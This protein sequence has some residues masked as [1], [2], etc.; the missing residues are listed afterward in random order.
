M[1]GRDSESRRWVAR[2]IASERGAGSNDPG[3]L[4]DSGRPPRPPVRP[5]RPCPED[6]PIDL[7]AL[8]EPV[9]GAVVAGLGIAVLGLLLLSLLHVRQLRRLRRR[10]DSLTRGADD[11]NLGTVLDAHLD[12]VYAV[13]REVDDLSARSAVLE[14]SG[15]RAIQRVGLVRF[16]PFEDTGGNQSFALA[17]TD[18]AGTGFVVNSLHSRNGTRVYAKAIVEGRSDGAL[19]AE[20]TEALRFALAQPSASGGGPARPRDRAS[21]AV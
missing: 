7:N 9:L 13:A 16:N 12:K 14:A 4:L 2:R 8:V 20:E 3:H 10:L 5:V 1:S 19:S 6:R 11:R 15:R 17:L 21:G 18:A